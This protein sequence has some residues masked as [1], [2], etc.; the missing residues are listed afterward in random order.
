MSLHFKRIRG[1]GCEA[2]FH[3]LQINLTGTAHR[4]RTQ[5]AVEIVK[6]VH[7]TLD[8][9]YELGLPLRF[10]GRLGALDVLMNGIDNVMEM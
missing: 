8:A 9:L 10:E 1:I 7:D 5:S 2:L 6:L 4:A 3:P